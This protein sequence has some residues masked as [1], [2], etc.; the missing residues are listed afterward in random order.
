MKKTS[1]AIAIT[2][3]V[4]A[5]GSITQGAEAWGHKPSNGQGQGS[6]HH[7]M[8]RGMGQGDMSRWADGLSLS[9]K[10]KL[11]VS[12]AQENWDK[13]NGQALKDVTWGL[14]DYR[15]DLSAGR[16]VDENSV[17]Q[18]REKM[19]SLEVSRMKHHRELYGLLDQD[20][21]ALAE[22]RHMDG[23]R[24][25]QDWGGRGPASNAIRQARDDHRKSMEALRDDMH[26]AMTGSPSEADLRALAEKRVDL[27]L[28]MAR[29]SSKA[30][31]DMRNSSETFQG[32]N[33]RGQGKGAPCF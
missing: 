3:A 18:L 12:E 22:K 26:K 27:R 13:A 10:Q 2:A 6:R 25:R 17:S 21:R 23:P 20:Q 24:N 29:S 1:V 19:I 33:R 9:A 5:L 15:Y 31:L 28:E 32:G 30:R 14:R 11:A 16:S 8:E 4:L 7:N